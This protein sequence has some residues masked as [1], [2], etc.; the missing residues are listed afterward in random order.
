MLTKVQKWGN[1]QG[2]RFPKEILSRANIS[3]G[4]EV[5]I[6]IHNG[7]IVIKPVTRIRGKYNLKDLVSKIPDNY[8][9]E[10]QNWGSPVGKEE[11]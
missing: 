1:S 11:W 6:E 8:M 10:E 3:I 4:D 2:L 7:E 9:S 5:D